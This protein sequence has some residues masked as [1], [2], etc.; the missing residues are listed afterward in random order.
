M[1][2]QSKT[3]IIIF[4][5]DNLYND[6]FF[7]YILF[8]QKLGLTF[9]NELLPNWYFCYLNRGVTSNKHKKSNILSNIFLK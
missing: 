1:L 4:S 9:V 2:L 3:N 6:K 7:F 8:E 5:C